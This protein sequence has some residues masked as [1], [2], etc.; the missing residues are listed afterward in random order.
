MFRHLLP[1]TPD[2][3]FSVLL[4]SNIFQ[5]LTSGLVR[6][7]GKQQIFT[8]QTL[9]RPKSVEVNHGTKW[10]GDESVVKDSPAA[11]C[12]GR[13]GGDR[14]PTG[15]SAP[16]RGEFFPKLSAAIFALLQPAGIHT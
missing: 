10:C 3:T 2:S 14:S 5:F 15:S 7:L 9:T 1:R 8:H 16:F 12:L 13:R 4:L 6:A 11:A